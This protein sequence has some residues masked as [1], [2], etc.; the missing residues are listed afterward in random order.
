MKKKKDN[1]NKKGRIIGIIILIIIMGSVYF[2]GING[3]SNETAGSNIDEESETDTTTKDDSAYVNINFIDYNGFQTLYGGS[4]RTILVLGQTGCSHC[5]E[6]KPTLNEIAKE[7]NIKINYLDIRE[8][9]QEEY[10]NLTNKLN[11]YFKDHEKWGTPLTIIL[12]NKTIIDSHEGY[13]E[14]NETLEFYK[15][16]KIVK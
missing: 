16:N 1:K 9:S 12:E 13:A 4:D 10:A 3:S 11:D 2:Q 14:K 15:E 7:E 5:D 8:L 6:Y